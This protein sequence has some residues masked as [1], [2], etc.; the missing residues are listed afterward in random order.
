M[1][2]IAAPTPSRRPVGRPREFDINQALTKAMEVFWQH[3]YHDTSIDD[4][5]ASTGLTKGSLYKAFKDKKHLFLAAFDHYVAHSVIGP[6]ERR[7]AHR[8]P[9]EALITQLFKH[10]A[11][12][13]SLTQGYR[14]CMITST[15]MEMLPHDPDIEKRVSQALDRTR[16][17]LQQA[18]ALGKEQGWIDSSLNE[19]T[20][21]FFL[22][23]QLQ[24]M[25]V[26][27]KTAPPEQLMHGTI[28]YALRALK[29]RG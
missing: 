13:S 27:G 25:R 22:L 28:D 3:G 9:A 10:Y 2:T 8:E 11:R 7:L 6:F 1:T 18:L 5:T 21:A 12:V 16:H 23:T 26:L 29:P 4:L 24:G 17:F 19:E 14:G 15:A 20:A